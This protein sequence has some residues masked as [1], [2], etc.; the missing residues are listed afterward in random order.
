MGEAETD[1]VEPTDERSPA[2]IWLA[3]AMGLVAVAYLAIGAHGLFVVVGDLFDWAGDNAFNWPGMTPSTAR[4]DLQSDILEL[5]VQASAVAAVGVVLALWRRRP[6]ALAVSGG[7]VVVALVVGLSAWTLVSPDEPDRP[8]WE[9][10]PRGCV[11]LS[12]EPSDCP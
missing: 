8:D 9:D 11:E 12:G 4:Q 3:A 1:E 2:P 5:T 6:L 10:R 7:G